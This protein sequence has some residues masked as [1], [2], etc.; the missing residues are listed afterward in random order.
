[1]SDEDDMCQ[2]IEKWSIKQCSPIEYTTSL[3]IG[4][5][6]LKFSKVYS[7][8]RLDMQIDM[9]DISTSWFCLFFFHHRASICVNRLGSRGFGE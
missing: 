2:D 6:T 3:N 1:M 4:R 5:I 8:V 7:C 9:H